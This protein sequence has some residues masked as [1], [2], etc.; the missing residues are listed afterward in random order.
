MSDCLLVINAGSS[1]IK[2]ALYRLDNSD[3]SVELNGQVAAIG[4]QGHFTVTDADRGVLV[5]Q[6][7]APDAAAQHSQAFDVIYIWLLEYLKERKL[8]AVGHRIVHGGQ[9]YAAPVLVDDIVLA[10]LQE[11][12]PLAPLHQPH[13]LASI[14]ELKKLLPTLPQVA[15]FDTAFHRTQP[16]VAQRLALPRQFAE[17][18]VKRYGFHGLSYEYIAELLPQLNLVDARVIV[19]HLGSGASLCALKDGQSV[20]TTM[21]FS[22]LDGLVM[23]TRCGNL[24]PGVLLYLMDHYQMDVRAL[25]QLLYYQAG[26]LGVSGISSDMATLLVSDDVHA[27]EA[28][29]L[30]LYRVSRE[31]GSLA[32]ALGGI[33]ALVFTGGIGEHSALIR[34]RICQQ[35]AWLGITLDRQANQQQGNCFAISTLDSSVAVWVAQTDENLM[36]ARH[37]LKSLANNPIAC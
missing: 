6:L 9:L 36:I 34:E 3:L 18:G 16:D 30:F 11:L 27:Q 4:A 23:G 32:A 1:S 19:A 29:E 28:V 15:C 37:A 2:F 26:L 12:V 35:A 10:Q 25:E 7:L 13:N 5:D 21:G 31:M 17:A 20:A 22:P 8:L 24:D 14:R 33:D